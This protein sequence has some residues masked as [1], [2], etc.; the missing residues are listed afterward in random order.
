V[1]FI[2]LFD[3]EGKMK[4]LKWVVYII[5]SKCVVYY[6]LAVAIDH[7]ILA[8]DAFDVAIDHCVNF[9]LRVFGV[10]ECVNS[11]HICLADK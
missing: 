3:Y 7:W 5:H 1:N 11:D 9:V 6:I 8:V 2:T 10:K 4:L